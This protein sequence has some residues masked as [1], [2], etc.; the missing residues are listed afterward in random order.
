MVMSVPLL[1]ATATGSGG[2][3]LVVVAAVAIG[4][5]L[6]A[7]LL[8]EIHVRKKSSEAVIRLGGRAALLALAGLDGCKTGTDE[9]VVDHEARGGIG[10]GDGDAVAVVAAAGL[11]LDGGAQDL[12]PHEH[13]EHNS[14]F[15][16]V[17]IVVGRAHL[18][19]GQGDLDGLRRE[20]GDRSGVERAEVSDIDGLGVSIVDEEDLGLVGVKGEHLCAVDLAVLR[21]RG[22]AVCVARGL[23]STRRDAG[24]GLL[25]L[26]GDAGDERGLVGVGVGRPDMRIELRAGEDL[27]DIDAD[28]G[29]VDDGV[30][31]RGLVDVAFPD[32]VALGLDGLL[33][34]S[35]LAAERNAV[36]EVGV[37]K[38]F[39]DEDHGEIDLSCAGF[40]E[41]TADESAVLVDVVDLDLDIALEGSVAD[42]SEGLVGEGLGLFAFLLC[43]LVAADAGKRED[44]GGRLLGHRDLDAGAAEDIVD[45]GLDLAR[46]GEE[47]EERLGLGRVV[48]DLV[49]MDRGRDLGGVLALF[50]CN[51]LGLGG[52]EIVVLEGAVLGVLSELDDGGETG[53]DE[54]L[55][56]VVSVVCE[57]GDAGLFREALG[58]GLDKV[59]KDL[60]DAAD[61]V[62]ADHL[63]SLPGVRCGLLVLAAHLGHADVGE[64]DLA[65]TGDTGDV[66]EDEAV[67]GR[68]L[69]DTCG[70]LAGGGRARGSRREGG[71]GWG[72]KVS[73]D[74][75][76]FV[77]CGLFGV[78][79]C[80]GG[81]GACD[82][83]RGDLS[84]A[85]AEDFLAD[86]AAL[87]SDCAKEVA[88]LVGAFDVDEHV[89]VEHSDLGKIFALARLRSD[90]VRGSVLALLD[91]SALHTA[92]GQCNDLARRNKQDLERVSAH[93]ILDNTSDLLALKPL[94][95][96]G[97]V[98]VSGIGRCRFFLSAPKSKLGGTRNSLRCLDLLIRVRLGAD[99][100][101]TGKLGCNILAIESDHSKLTTGLSAFRGETLS[102]FDIDILSDEPSSC[103]FPS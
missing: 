84:E 39:L 6:Q 66:C 101:K 25:C 47:A 54:I 72:D 46:A 80:R 30:L 9:T 69:D 1:E 18:E 19:M 15:C 41:N 87:V 96:C 17:L 79:E 89:A 97:V 45:N 61:E 42:H 98:F 103:D 51:G 13:A 40:D 86:V 22:E 2:L 44:K 90:G 29:A 16:A 23:E 62:L 78:S 60:D 35:E 12:F 11:L 49:E 95:E 59:D 63:A 53:A 58:G 71:R 102:D 37:C 100:A 67:C 8:G 65:L 5:E 21:V 28:R 88:V 4:P 56:K 31:L 34:L 32:A 26:G 43:G 91:C 36:G 81:G 74:A 83:P 20:P 50:L 48:G 92:Q 70:V 77:S 14:G 76:L 57:G 94:E 10:E 75:E 55:G 64:E 33:G 38:T 52:E 93:H 82:R 85:H 73:P 68:G 24:H 27:C 7:A 3:D 99:S